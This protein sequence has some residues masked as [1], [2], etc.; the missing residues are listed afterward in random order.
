MP[1]KKTKSPLADVSD[2][3][4][5]YGAG[6]LADAINAYWLAKGHKVGAERYELPG[7]KAAYGV[8]SNLLNGLPR[9]PV[10]DL[11]ARRREFLR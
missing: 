4:S 7:C 3:L 9:P 1:N 2:L 5:A 8:R 6:L 11:S 10:L